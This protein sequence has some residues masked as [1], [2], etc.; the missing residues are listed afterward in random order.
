MSTKKSS[1]KLIS[2]EVSQEKLFDVYCDL[3]AESFVDASDEVK[4]F[5]EFCELR[6]TEFHDSFE[7]FYALS[8]KARDEY[9]S[10]QVK[11]FYRAHSLV[12]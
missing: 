11:R 5:I 2:K 12:A 4:A 1:R 8:E 9:L 10:I 6:T 7:A 3:Y